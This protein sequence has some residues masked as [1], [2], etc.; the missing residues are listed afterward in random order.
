MDVL[1]SPSS[2]GW[3]R[4]LM[5]VVAR[6][7][8]EAPDCEPQCGVGMGGIRSAFTSLSLSREGD[9]MMVVG[10]VL[11]HVCALYAI[12]RERAESMTRWILDG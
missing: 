6:T 1:R 11:E 2:T 3:G 5:V 7:V 12:S 9:A 8:K 10:F 4:A